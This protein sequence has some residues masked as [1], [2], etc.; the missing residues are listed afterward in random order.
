MA[1]R[2]LLFPWHW[3][4]GQESLCAR[5]LQ[6]FW[7]VHHQSSLLN[8]PHADQPIDLLAHFDAA[9]AL[10]QLLETYLRGHSKL[11]SSSDL[12][13]LYQEPTCEKNIKHTLSNEWLFNRIVVI[14]TH[15]IASFKA[16]SK[17]VANAVISLPRHALFSVLASHSVASRSSLISE[18]FNKVINNCL[19]TCYNLE[20]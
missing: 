5:H 4:K 11:L 7:L 18:I 8:A 1:Y 16:G 3:S 2:S 19:N 9:N 15:C 10:V 20:V 13:N 6:L 12:D 14:Q 17:W